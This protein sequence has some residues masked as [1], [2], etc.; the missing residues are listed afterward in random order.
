[1]AQFDSDFNNFFKRQHAQNA[2][3]VGKGIN[4]N[5]DDKKLPNEKERKIKENQFLFD[6]GADSIF[7]QKDMDLFVR[8]N[9]KTA[10][11]ELNFELPT[12]YKKIDFVLDG[13][14]YSGG[15]KASGMVEGKYYKNGVLHTGRVG[16][17]TY[18][19]GNELANGETYIVNSNGVAVVTSRD[20]KT[21]KCY[22]K[23]GEIVSTIINNN[24]IGKPA[25]KGSNSLEFEG[26]KIISVENGD[27][28]VINEDGTVAVTSKDGK[29]NKLYTRDGSLISR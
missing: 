11:G 12:N 4:V 29:T 14:A 3:E 18:I 26:G 9:D 16:L 7:T 25:I 20:W 8:S 21:Q 10:S 28:A 1:M 24:T 15:G 2:S 19:Y 23:S 27:T 17:K 5:F 13:I 22:D 6:L